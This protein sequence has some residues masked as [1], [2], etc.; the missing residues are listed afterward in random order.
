MADE[1]KLFGT[2]GVRG[3]AN[4]DPI[5]PEMVLKLGRAAADVFKNKGKKTKILIGKDTRISGYIL[6]TALTSGICSMGVDV[7]LVGPLPTPAIAHLTKSFGA[8]AGVV[9]SASHNPAEHNGIK[10]FSNNGFKLPDQKELEM[11]NI[12]YS[13][14]FNSEHINGRS[15]GKAFR[16]DD[17]K[18]RYIEFAKSTINNA[19]LSGLKV[20]LDCANGAA[21][22]VAPT[23]LR[24]LGADVIV[25][26]NRP[27]GLNINQNCGAMHTEVIS[28]AVKKEGAN[29]GIALDGDADRVMMVDEKGE[30]FDGDFIMALC[31]L[32]LKKR[33]MLKKDTIVATTMSNIGLE[34]FCRDN[35]INFV[36][37]DVGDRYVIKEMV[38]NGFSFGGE[39][40]G[41]ICFMD[42]ITTGDGIITALQVL[43]IL[44]DTGKRLSE[45]RLFKRLPQVLEN[46][47]V[48]ERL[49]FENMPGLVDRMKEAE[50]EL[51]ENGR[52]VIRYSGTENI[53]RVMIEG[54]DEK[55]IKGLADGMSEEIKK[56]I[57]A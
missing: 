55:I 42:Y 30:E 6:E 5:T 8:D 3:I 57:G 38:E 45:L 35:G 34:V 23:I 51:G 12:V 11:E 14:S 50:R 7:L 2:D 39:Q 56:E 18:G 27:D 28:D 46:I 33:G 1:R 54:Q 53:A 52:V 24:E 19:N 48:R 47:K 36:R 21:Y 17:A 13:E 4:K 29:I 31:G 26:N 37:T 20:V 40:S 10:F 43:N 15:I 9:I 41:H 49:G 32:E 22:A 16:I 44:K 25:L